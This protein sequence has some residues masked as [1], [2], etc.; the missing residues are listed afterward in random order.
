MQRVNA[1]WGGAGQNAFRAGRAGSPLPA[2]RLAD[3]AAQDLRPLPYWI[4]QLEDVS[5]ARSPRRLRHHASNFRLILL[6]S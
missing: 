6:A 3:G 2:E 4:R 5:L 1:R